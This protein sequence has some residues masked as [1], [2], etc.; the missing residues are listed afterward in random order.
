MSIA[1]AMAIAPSERMTERKTSLSVAERVSVRRSSLAEDQ[2]EELQNLREKFG[3]SDVDESRVL[4]LK[5]QSRRKDE[6]TDEG[7]EAEEEER[8]LAAQRAARM[9]MV[10]RAD[11]QGSSTG[12]SSPRSPLRL[13]FMGRRS[14]TQV[15]P[16]SAKQ[17]SEQDAKDTQ[18][19]DEPEAKPSMLTRIRNSIAG[20]RNSIVG[21][22]RA[23][24]ADRSGSITS[25][26]AR[27]SMGVVA[28]TLVFKQKLQKNSKANKKTVPLST[29]RKEQKIVDLVTRLWTATRSQY[30]QKGAWT[31]DMYMDYHL[32]LYH[33]LEK[34]DP[35]SGQPR[36]EEELKE[37][38]LD[39]AWDSGIEDWESDSSGRK[40][41]AFTAFF[42]SVFEL[43]TLYAEAKTVAD[44]T[45]F[46]KGLIE[47]TTTK[48][49]NFKE[50]GER[51]W[52]YKY[53]R[54]SSVEAL[55]A[56]R[57]ALR[58]AFAMPDTMRIPQGSS[59]PKSPGAAHK[60]LPP[61]SPRSA[62]AVME[63]LES[64]IDQHG[65]VQGELEDASISTP[66][67]LMVALAS[68]CD[69]AAPAGDGFKT[70]CDWI[71]THPKREVTDDASRGRLISLFYCLDATSCDGRLTAN[72]LLGA[73]RK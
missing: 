27:V 45:R 61:P 17:S 1:E 67:D 58:T 15:A 57:S 7:A 53:P 3:A 21:P 8:K 42:S 47:G 35:S 46:L 13:S 26:T 29:L 51:D 20:G 60:H 22:K 64:W 30:M 12:S 54:D 59:G 66:A 44:F 40:H 38:I 65:F 68:S 19:D 62:T 34:I 36:S 71:T 73:L 24:Q 70:V 23:S 6:P 32:S 55:D 33:Y 2:Q 50:H 39:T 9:T 28:L 52:R 56:A 72:D 43:T 37:S 14:S 16:A 48:P 31:F 5:E 49:E 41:L 11:G 25:Q 69:A 10:V 63:K 18:E 4:W